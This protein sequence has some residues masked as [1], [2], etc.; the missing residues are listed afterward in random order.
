[1]FMTFWGEEKIPPEA[2]HHAHESPLV[3]TLPLMVLAVFAIGIGFL[4]GPLMPS[5]LQFAHF[6]GYTP[7]FPEAEHHGLDAAAWGM[8]ALSAV[9]AVG[10]IGLAYLMYV[11]RPD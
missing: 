10:G 1:Y 6:L 7:G 9:V 11:A 8:M 4:V 3:M 5:A 2:G